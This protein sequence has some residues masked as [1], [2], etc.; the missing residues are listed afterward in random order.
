M[1]PK[2]FLLLMTATAVASDSLLHPFYP[3]YFAEVLSVSDPMHVGLYIAACSLTALIAF[4]IWALCA[5]HVSVLYLLIITQVA[6]GALSLACWRVQSVGWFWSLSLLMIVFKAS[7][8]LIYP[9][10]MTLEPRE[11]HVSTIGLLAFVV[12][13]GN[14]VA[15]L[16]SGA[17]FEW[18]E[19]RRLF[20]VMAGG[21][22]VQTLLAV[23]MLKS[24]RPPVES[25]PGTAPEPL[26][27][28][29][30]SELPTAPKHFVLKLGVVMFGMYFSAY[31]PEP[32]FSAYWEGTSALDNRVLSGVVFAAPALAAL[33]GLYLD[34]KRRRQANPYAGIAPAVAVGIGSVWLMASGIPL[35]VLA[36]RC[37]YGW[38]LFQS[39]VRLDALLFRVAA[40][41]EYAVEFSKFNVFQGLGVLSASMV[42]GSAA[43]SFGLGATF[44]LSA[45]GFAAA[46]VMYAGMFKSELWPGLSVRV[47]AQE[48][49]RRVTS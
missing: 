21:D 48:R 26:Q 23:V 27:E 7:Y 36:G 22:A 42:A 25:P 9:F 12:H 46:L 37:L 29:V 10:V 33:L 19:P 17:V 15:A 13:F 8:L 3:Q 39:M 28:Q 20:L 47:A 18:L 16:I 38:A 2:L 35:V 45:A 30:Q 24:V 40:T 1:S 31:L 32:F 43:S 41:N 4:P 49:P 11:R 34:G 6:T 44:A 14:I 5:R